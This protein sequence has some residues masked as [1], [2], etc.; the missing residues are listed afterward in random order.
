MCCNASICLRSGVLQICF[1]FLKWLEFLCTYN[2]IVDAGASWNRQDADHTW[3]SQCCF[4]L[5]TGQTASQ[6]V[7]SLRLYY[8]LL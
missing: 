4:A 7:H 6:V 3:C 2:C 5:H 1:L 8:F